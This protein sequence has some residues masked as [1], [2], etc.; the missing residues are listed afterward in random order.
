MTKSSVGFQ[1]PPSPVYS[2]GRRRRRREY[3]AVEGDDLLGS[4]SDDN[5]TGGG[6]GDV[7]ENGADNIEVRVSVE[8]S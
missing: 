6:G 1:V 3:E 4:A 7:A 2:A 5:V 8:A